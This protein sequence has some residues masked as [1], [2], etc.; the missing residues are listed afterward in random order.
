MS[1]ENVEVAKRLIDAFNATNVD[2]FTALTTPDF[3]W[4]PSM[5]AIEAEVFRG[6]EGI[7]RYFANLATAWEEF[8][9]IR[10][11]FRDH[12]DVVVMLGALR[13]RGRNSGV[14]VNSSL[15]MVFDFRAGAV[16]RIRGFL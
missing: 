5:A 2:A 4:S 11:E 16:S 13:G 6:S 14:T 10:D 12:G 9:I 7:D 8:H 1:Q 3:A 15:G